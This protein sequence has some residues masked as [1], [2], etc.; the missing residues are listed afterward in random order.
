MARIGKHN[1]GHREGCPQD[2]PAGFYGEYCSC[3]WLDHIVEVKSDS[4]F[5]WRNGVYFKRMDNQSVRLRI[6]GRYNGCPN[7]T[8]HEI[9][10]NEW[11]SII[12]SVS[13]NGENSETFQKAIMFHAAPLSLVSIGPEL[14]APIEAKPA[15]ELK[16]EQAEEEFYKWW[17]PKTLIGGRFHGYSENWGAKDAWVAARSEPPAEASREGKP[18]IKNAV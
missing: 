7:Y 4:G 10:P 11:A 12:S 5:H 13:H 14:G 9:P 15:T 16:S 17:Q 8:D 6:F 1:R 2:V 18:G 3:E